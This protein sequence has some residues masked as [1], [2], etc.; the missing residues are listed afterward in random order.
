VDQ[1]SKPVLIALAAVVVLAAAKFTVLRPKDDSA[2]TPPVATAPGQEGLTRAVDNS[3]RAVGVN[4]AAVKQHEKAATE[5][6]SPAK[7]ATPAKA[8]ATA[9]PKAAAPKPV[10]AKP[11]APKLAE[12]DR[13]GP[14]LE[15]LAARKIAVV[16][17]YNSVGA[18]DK[19]VLS[20]VR[21]AD[22]RH[23]L[24]KVHLM[25][26]KNVDYDALTTGVQV[27]Q[28]P[29]LL[30]IGPDHKARTLVGYTEVKEVDQT[31][32][33]VARANKLLK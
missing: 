7:P 2:S 3:N 20:A 25:P 8:K 26:I 16:L 22:R 24:V 31:V 1:V 32:F 5:T 13:S 4:N 17:F 28:S 29:T 9:A 10:A 30:V 33:D 23:G 27:L 12:G 21:A 6:T 14:I 11:A 18:D 19:A 15:Q